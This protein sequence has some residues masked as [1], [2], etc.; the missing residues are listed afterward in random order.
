MRGGI[1]AELLTFEIPRRGLSGV[2]GEV[3]RDL[4]FPESY[5][6]KML[7]DISHGV[8]LPYIVRKPVIFKCIDIF[9]R[10]FAGLA[11]TCG[12]ANVVTYIECQSLK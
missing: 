7:A 5:G 2:R 1:S 11:A 3:L 9:L 8:T 12:N 4:L 10:Y 6:L